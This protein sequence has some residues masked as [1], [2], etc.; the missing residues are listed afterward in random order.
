MKNSESK[1][2]LNLKEKL[3]SKSTGKPLIWVEKA[4]SDMIYKDVIKGTISIT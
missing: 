2:I 3:S 1:D 4:P